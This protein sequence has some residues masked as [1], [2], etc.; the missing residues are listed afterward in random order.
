MSSWVTDEK[1][2]WHPAKERVALRN[3]SGKTIEIEQTSSDGKKFKQSVP[4]GADYIYEGPDRAALFDWWEQNGKPNE[5][6]MKELNGNVT[7][8]TDFRQNEEFLQFYAKMKNVFGFNTIGEFLTYL[9]YDEKKVKEEFNAKAQVV[10]LHELPSRVPEIKRA[11]G[12]K[13]EANPVEVVYGGFG[14][15]PGVK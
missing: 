15:A 10:K 1:G 14:E 6:K 4:P 2:V 13:N 9:G 7:L 3:L 8:G 12:G 11:G 5:A